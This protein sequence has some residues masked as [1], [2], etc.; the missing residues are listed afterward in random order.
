M[1]A[2]IADLLL[3]ISIFVAHLTIAADEYFNPD[4]FKSSFTFNFI[5]NK[6]ITNTA[7]NTI[8]GK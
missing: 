3:Q 5:A 6:K 1:R 4:F 8:S 2:K 7:W